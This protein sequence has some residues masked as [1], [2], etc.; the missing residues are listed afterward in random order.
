MS[1]K[2]GSGAIDPYTYYVS[3]VEPVVSQLNHL[4]GTIKYF[5]LYDSIIREVESKRG[6]YLGFLPGMLI[7]TAMLKII[8]D[9]YDE[10]GYETED[11]D[12]TE[13]DDQY[14][15]DLI[16]TK[17]NE[18][19]VAQVKSGIMSGGEMRN[20]CTSA[21]E[22]IIKYQPGKEIKRL[23]IS[24]YRLDKGA[25]EVFAEHGRKMIKEG[26]ALSTLIPEA[27]MNALPKYRRHF[28]ELSKIHSK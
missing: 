6:Q 28:K 1:Y 18:I 26:F 9:Y 14:K 19:I 17:E 13:I 23:V 27:I 22:F 4:E 8:S 10:L 12:G 3:Q 15:I 25:H 21:P 11:T 16:A 7:G 2:P 20:F 24:A 5:D